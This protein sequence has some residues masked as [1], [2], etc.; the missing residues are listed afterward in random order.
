MVEN[1]IIMKQDPSF[2]KSFKPVGTIAFIIVLLVFTALV[3]FS[4]YNLQ[5]TRH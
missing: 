4:I 5:I 2:D 3:W 1:K